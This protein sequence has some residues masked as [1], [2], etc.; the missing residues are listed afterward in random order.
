VR[1]RVSPEKVL[2]A[3]MG[4]VAIAL[5]E[6]QKIA[7]S[8][9]R[10]QTLAGSA[11]SLVQVTNERTSPERVIEVTTTHIQEQERMSVDDIPKISL[12]QVE[13]NSKQTTRA[14]EELSVVTSEDTTDVRVLRTEDLAMTLSTTELEKIELAKSL[15]EGKPVQRAGLVFIL[16]QFALVTDIRINS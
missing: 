1:H 8:C 3:A 12:V 13:R 7:E 6:A 9:V 14:L 4:E 5:L 16:Y 2:D 10:S 11:F 15:K